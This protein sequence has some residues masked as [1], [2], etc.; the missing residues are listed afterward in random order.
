MI[1]E[2]IIY[3]AQCKITG[4]IYIGQTIQSLI[5]RK[6][7]HRNNYVESDCHFQRAI[8]LYGF[9]QFI[10][11]ILVTAPIEELDDWERYFVWFYQSYMGITPLQAGTSTTR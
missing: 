10:W 1:R 7:G 6:R 8:A 5:A 4:K 3:F 11:E 2:G 9:D